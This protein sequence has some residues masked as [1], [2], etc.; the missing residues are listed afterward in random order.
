MNRI[1]FTARD[2]GHPATM[3]NEVNPCGKIIFGKTQKKIQTKKTRFK[4][5]PTLLKNKNPFISVKNA[6][7]TPKYHYFASPKQKI[8]L[9]EV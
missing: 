8:F 1:A 4:I 2:K 5:N 9:Y 6:A 3:S 7:N